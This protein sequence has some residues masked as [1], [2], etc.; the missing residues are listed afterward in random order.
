MEERGVSKVLTG[1]SC[2]LMTLTRL[3]FARQRE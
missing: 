2:L 3:A 1:Y